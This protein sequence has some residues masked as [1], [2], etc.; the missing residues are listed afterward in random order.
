MTATIELADVDG[1]PTVVSSRLRVRATVPGI[2]DSGSSSFVDEAIALRPI[3]RL[4]AGILITV[5][6]TLDQELTR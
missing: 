6:A 5:D 1:R 3:S 2:D 4:F